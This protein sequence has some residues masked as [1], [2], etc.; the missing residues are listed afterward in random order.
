MQSIERF[1][2]EQ[3]AAWEV[4]GCAIAAVRDG[5]VAVPRVAAARAGV[6]RGERALQRSRGGTDSWQWQPRG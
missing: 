2:A 3:L 4:P 1:V 6:S 5:D